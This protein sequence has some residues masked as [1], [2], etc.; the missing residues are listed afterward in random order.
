MRTS[1]RW[2]VNLF[3]N[4]EFIKAKVDKHISSS[5]LPTIY[6]MANSSNFTYFGKL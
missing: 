4:F 1:A 3:Q 6:T 5:T 2:V